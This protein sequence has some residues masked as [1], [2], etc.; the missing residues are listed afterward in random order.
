MEVPVPIVVIDWGLYKLSWLLAPIVTWLIKKHRCLIF[1]KNQTN[2]I[3]KKAQKTTGSSN[4]YRPDI[5][6]VYFSFRTFSKY[7]FTSLR[8]RFCGRATKVKWCLNTNCFQAVWSNFLFPEGCW[9][10]VG[11]YEPCQLS[12]F[13]TVVAWINKR[14]NLNLYF[15]SNVIELT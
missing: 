4:S 14:S 2:I 3:A 9:D 10:S 7:S 8:N 1:V 12:L 13:H 6:A 11:G 15:L 5:P